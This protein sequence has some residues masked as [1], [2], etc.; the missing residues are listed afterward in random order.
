MPKFE[1]MQLPAAKLEGH[2]NIA[3]LQSVVVLN[4]IFCVQA[5]MAIVCAC[6]GV[7]IPLF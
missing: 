4:Q 5:N 3:S 7:V 6:A 2:H 1:S